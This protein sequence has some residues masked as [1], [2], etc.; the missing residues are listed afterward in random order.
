MIDSWSSK[1]SLT[2]LA[3]NVF[4]NCLS[5]FGIIIPLSK[6]A[7]STSHMSVDKLQSVDIAGVHPSE[8][9]DVSRYISCGKNGKLTLLSQLP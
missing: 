6:G 1:D 3:H 4:E 8:P 7:K 5:C 9:T 2:K